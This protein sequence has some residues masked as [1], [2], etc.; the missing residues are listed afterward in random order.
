M[1]ICV[2]LMN[3]SFFLGLSNFFIFALLILMPVNPVQAKTPEPDH[4]VTIYLFWGDG[5]PH[6]AKAK[7]YFEGLAS[8]Y[9]EVEL[10]T[11]EIYYDSENQWLFSMMAKQHD[12]NQMAVPTIF[13]GSYLMQGYSENYNPEIEELVKKC[14]RE[15]CEDAGIGVIK[16]TVDVKTLV[17]SLSPSETYLPTLVETQ[18][19]IPVPTQLSSNLK[20]QTKIIGQS[21]DLNIPLLGKINLDSESIILSTVLIALV[22]GVNPCSL[23]V[24][25]MLMVLTLHSGSR[26]KV[27]IIGVVFLTVTAGFYALFILGLF[28]VLKITGFI[29]WI[30]IAVA[31]IALFFAIVNIK[32]YFWFK[33]GLS[34]TIADEK[35]PGLIK[36]MRSVLDASQ[37]FFGLVSATVVLATGVSLV[38]FSCTAGFPVIW[39]NMLTAQNV[40][41][42]LFLVLLI[43]Y[44]LIYQLDEMVIFISSV[45]TLKASRVEEKHGRILKLISGMLMFSLALVMLINPTLMN[46]LSGSLIVFGVAFSASFLILFIHRILLPK[47]GVDINLD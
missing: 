12:L 20:E 3:R 11:Y 27:F 21:H 35:K 14:I 10:K 45:V 5:C 43:L 7:P 33:E 24:L 15:G 29:G 30:R 17:P 32:D 28:S 36:K 25:T 1:Y 31:L 4:T 6:C 34:L 46:D 2:K 42:T 37:S 9:P 18:T 16:K 40:N 13:I 41:G 39:T 47:L 8:R 19:P 44:M 22:D 38:E 26:K 23:W